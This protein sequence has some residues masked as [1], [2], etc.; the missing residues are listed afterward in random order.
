M[1]PYRKTAICVGALFLIAMVTYLVGASIIDTFISSPDFLNEVAANETTVIM[2]V[3]LEL[4]NV[5][6]VIGIGA[7]MFSVLKKENEALA[8]NYVALRILEATTLVS[9]AIIPL[10]LI[11]LSQAFIVGNLAE[12]SNFQIIGDLFITA[13]AYLSGIMTTIFFSLG[14]LILYF[15]LYRTKLVPLWLSVWGLIAAVMVLIWNLLE[16]F[17]ISLNVG[18]IFG[19]PIILNEIVLGIWLIVKGF[20]SNAIASQ[21]SDKDIK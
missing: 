11:A 16:V 17:S 12:V 18:I 3:L 7:G 10:L 14:A 1:N 9:A 20:D 19:L 8:L 5:L 21:S 4:V 2:G 15:L 13:R 6:A